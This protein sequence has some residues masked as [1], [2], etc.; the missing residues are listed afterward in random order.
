M[1]GAIKEKESLSAQAH[2]IK[3]RKMVGAKKERITLCAGA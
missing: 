3:I 1:V 2:K